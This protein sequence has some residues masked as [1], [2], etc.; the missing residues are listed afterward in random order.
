MEHGRIESARG[1]VHA[2]HC[3]HMGHANLR[4]YGELFEQALWHVFLV[5]ALGP[6]RLRS[7]DIRMAGVQQNITYRRELFAGDCVVVR[8]RLTH[9]GARKLTMLHEMLVVESKE[10]CATCELTAVCIDS[11]TRRPVNL[12]IEVAAEAMRLLRAAGVP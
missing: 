4:I 12:P 6:S 7:G 5:I 2:W 8:S 1:V 9:V 3:D 11:V 10:V